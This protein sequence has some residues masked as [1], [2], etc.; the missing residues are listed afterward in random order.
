[1]TTA[2]RSGQPQLSRTITL[3]LL[4][5][6]GL[7]TTVGAGIYVIIG[8]TAALSGYYLPV[9]FILAALIASLSAASFAELSVRYPVSAGEAVYIREGFGL[10]NI[11]LLAG[12]AIATSGAV[13]SA[14]LLQGGVGYLKQIVSAPD[15]L[16]FALLLAGLGAFAAWGV[17]KSLL[18]TGILTL[19]EIG[20]LVAVI[21]YAPADPVTMA[22][23]AAALASRIDAGVIVGLTASA[24]LAFF[25]FIGFEDMV[26]VVEEVKAPSRTMPL[27]IGL[28][29]VITTIFYV[30]IALIAVNAVAPGALAASDAP[31][32]E[33]FGRLSGFDTGLFSV[34]ALLAVINGVLIQLVMSS[35][36]LYGLARQGQLPAILGQVS[37]ATRTP[38]VA[39]A[40]VCA[41]ILL[42]GSLFSLRGLA[43]TTSSLTLAALALVNLSLWRLK[44]G[45]SPAPGA[46][47]IPRIIPLLGFVTS[48]LLLIAELA[49]RITAL[50]Q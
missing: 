50:F 37:K 44:G 11:S 1:M 49:R 40:V 15:M 6:Y 42:I 9:A 19:V 34:V 46:F 32:A 8:E 4:T 41:A 22:A 30:W 47:N 24:L 35:R 10:R 43:Q 2:N 16:L 39:T 23:N 5:L 36:I 7:G 26:N 38:L 12:L 29:L 27:A 45:T 48:G 13:S 18:L 21:V 25:A 28:T 20:G 14:T 17:F 3:P 33:I 31:L